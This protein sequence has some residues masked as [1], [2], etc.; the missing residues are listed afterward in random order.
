MFTYFLCKEIEQRLKFP[1]FAMDYL[2][3]FKRMST[4]LSV[5]FICSANDMVVPKQEVEQFYHSYKGD[6]ELL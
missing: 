6:K 5:M 2:S 4:T 1:L 3:L